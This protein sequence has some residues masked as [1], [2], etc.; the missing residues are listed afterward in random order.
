M[1][2][3]G[4]KL[5]MSY[6]STGETI[7]CPTAPIRFQTRLS[8]VMNPRLGGTSSPIISPTA[9]DAVQAARPSPQILRL[10]DVCRVTGLCRSMIYQLEA[11]QRFPRRI[12]LGIRAVGWVH[13]EIQAWLSQRIE[14]NRA[15]RSA[16]SA[17][18]KC[19]L[20]GA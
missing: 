11:E 3:S 6:L 16:T 18:I 4:Q 8:I 9:L 10:R 19:R 2:C 13:A 7:Q 12:K 15:V 17:P 1:S 20:N 14:N 5:A